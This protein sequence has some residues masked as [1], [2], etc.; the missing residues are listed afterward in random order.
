MEAALTSQ[1]DHIPFYFLPS[2][3]W[4]RKLRGVDSTGNLGLLRLDGYTNFL[5]LM[6]HHQMQISP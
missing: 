3:L 2:Q 5:P 1:L 6:E 4:P